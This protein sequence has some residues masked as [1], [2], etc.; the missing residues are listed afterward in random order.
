MNKIIAV[1]GH[2][3]SRLGNEYDYKGP[4]SE[5]IYQELQ[6]LIEKMKPSHMISGMAL[7][8]DTIF[9][10]L[11]LG[12][13]IPLIAAI[14]FEGQ[15]RT[16]LPKN[17]EQYFDIINDP[18]TEKKYISEPGYV[19]WKMHKRDR[20]MVDN[21]NHLIVVWDSHPVGGTYSTLQYAI[22]IDR[23]HTII[24][25]NRWRLKTKVV[26]IKKQEAYDVYIGRG[27]KWGN[28][29]ANGTRIENI[30]KYRE[31]INNNS[32]LLNDLNEL[33]DKRLGCFCA[34]LPCHGDILI[35]LMLRHRIF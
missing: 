8:V 12:N 24:N 14:P 32:D 35:E 27:S 6:R 31:Y 19:A 34:P 9:A 22:E 18:L 20:W 10:H 33:K 23:P 3:P 5:W 15:E 4:Y 1:T 26:N 29:F 2:R 16:W 25:P 30:K 17:Q 28:P 7:G 13:S 21:C 11:A